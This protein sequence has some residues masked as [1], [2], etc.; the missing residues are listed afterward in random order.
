MIVAG[1]QY[2]ILVLYCNTTVY[3]QTNK[4]I[5]ER[6]NTRP[7]S[8]KTWYCIIGLYCTVQYPVQSTV[9]TV[10]VHSTTL[11]SPVAVG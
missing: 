6:K 7:Y 8:L 5:K 4:D 3:K 10:R 11:K 9:S 2:Y 1:K